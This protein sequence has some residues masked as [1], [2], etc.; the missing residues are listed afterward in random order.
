MQRFSLRSFGVSSIS[1]SA[2]LLVIL[3]PH[4]AH[5]AAGFFGPIISPECNCDTAVSGASGASAPSSA[6][7][8]GCILQTIQN[9]TS[10][11]ASFATIII[12]VFIALAGFSYM[13]S[14]ANA[15]KRQLANKR[16]INAVIGL[17]ITL[18]AFLLVDSILKVIYDPSTAKFGP[19]NSILGSNSGQDCLAVHNPPAALPAL[20]GAAAG[21]NGSGGAGQGGPTT[22]PAPNTNNSCSVSA[23]SG[24]FGSQAAM[25]SCVTRY[26]NGSCNPS[27]PS[28]TDIGADG[29]SVSYGLFQVNISANN[30]SSYPACE[31]AVNN[32]PLNCT[33]A[34]NTPYVGA[35]SHFTTRVLPNQQGLFNTCVRAASDPTCN[36]QAAK[37]LLN[38]S[39]GSLGPW[40]TNARNNCSSGG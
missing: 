4:F 6:A 12:A 40:G 23:L 39:G 24:V 27:A 8:W 11:A 15:E 13:T 22:V 14:G 9:L 21:S 20:F 18:C 30:L 37:D 32:A 19:W 31:A 10:F 29:N 25:M 36:E 33:S 1:L 26:E 16:L 2:L 28:G 3:L 17:L 34:F 5:A 7:A 35:S 38:K